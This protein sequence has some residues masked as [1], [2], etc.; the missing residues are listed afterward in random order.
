MRFLRLGFQPG[1]EGWTPNF[2]LPQRL[3]WGVGGA[4]EVVL[5]NRPV[6]RERMLRHISGEGTVR[7]VHLGIGAEVDHSRQLCRRDNVRAA[8]ANRPPPWVA[9]KED[10]GHPLT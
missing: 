1:L 10:R 8:A 4:D 5:A 6:D 3:V 9:R 7:P 2:G